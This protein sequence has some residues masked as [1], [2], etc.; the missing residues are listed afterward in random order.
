[1]A[2]DPSPHP[3]LGVG[4]P[5][6]EAIACDPAMRQ[7]I[8]PASEPQHEPCRPGGPTRIAGSHRAKTKHVAAVPHHPALNRNRRRVEER[9][10]IVIVVVVGNGGQSNAPIR[11]PIASDVLR[12]GQRAR[13]VAAAVLDCTASRRPSGVALARAVR[14][15]GPT[16]VTFRRCTGA[17]N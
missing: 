14:P 2:S 15:L 9:I 17:G 4:C 16:A 5:P 13:R 1:M 12:K 7:P 8:L 6:H 11:A 3:R 10:F